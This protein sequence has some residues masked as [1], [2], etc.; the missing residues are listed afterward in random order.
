MTRV[1]DLD[2]DRPIRKG[3]SGMTPDH[4]QALLSVSEAKLDAEG[5]S[6]TAEERWLTLHASRDGVGLT[7]GRVVAL[8]REGELV[9][10]RTTKG[11]QF[12][13]ALTDL[14]A[15]SIEASKER[16]RQAGFR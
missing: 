3:L 7:I 15:G 1:P 14:F 5:W 12:V 2:A 4:F 16:G 11:D 13:L 9:L 6:T 8:K 10:A